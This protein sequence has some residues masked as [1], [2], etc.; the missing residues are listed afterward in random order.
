M[1]F[2]NESTWSN[3]SSKYGEGEVHA[4]YEKAVDD[5]TG[6]LSGEPKVH[7]NFIGGKVRP[8]E[9]HFQVTS[10]I[11]SAITI[12]S[13]PKGSAK[14]ASDAVDAAEKAFQG[15]RRTDLSERLRILRRGADIIRR[16]RFELA[17]LLTMT[18]GKVRREAVG[19]VDMAI[20]YL[21]Y[22]AGEMERNDGYDREMPD[23]SPQE[24]ARNVFLPYGPWAVVCPFNFPFG[25]SMGML[26]GVLVTGNTAVIKP[27]SPS[28]APVYAIYD[29]LTRAGVPPGVLNLVAGSGGEVG[30][31]LVRHPKVE[32]V[33]FTG[34]REVGYSILRHNVDRRYPIPVILELGGKNAAIISSKA[35]LGRAVRG[36]VSSAFGYGG[37][38]CVAC[39]RVYVHKSMYEEFLYLL[40]KETE[41][42]KVMDPRLR[43]ART[44][45]VIHEGAVRSYEKA[46]STARHDGKVLTGGRRLTEDG[47]G[48][49]CFVA[50]TVVTDLPDVHDLVNN[51]LFLP[52]LCVLEFTELEDAVRR[53][54]GVPYGLTAGIYSDDRREVDFFLENMQCGMVYVNGV[55]GAT[56][57]AITGMHSFGGWKGSGS[58]GR[59]SGDIYYLLQFMR[60]QGRA[61]SPR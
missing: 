7:S 29:A 46:V 50:P 36:V 56:N 23:P 32:G 44:G 30:E 45:P 49:G 25:I 34:S 20:D 31:T 22:Y 6:S 8:A 26:A 2:A 47:L 4:R 57:G 18:N 59:G 48:R 51:E 13:F 33:I 15:W 35:D 52:F 16:E 24:R 17:A 58:T 3:Y 39:S 14:D 1:P 53:A 27:A 42:F 40:V 60:Q 28:P 43:D 55:R 54:N 12:G 19:E 5:L 9:A 37:Q 11:D 41:A 10:P 21:E 61:I 38:K